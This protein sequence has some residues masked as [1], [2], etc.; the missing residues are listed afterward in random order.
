MAFVEEVEAVIAHYERATLCVGD[1]FMKI[2]T[3]QLR[4]DI[5]FEAMALAPISTSE[6]LWR[7][8][9]VLALT[10]LPG[11]AP[12]VNPRA[13]GSVRAGS[14]RLLPGPARRMMRAP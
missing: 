4:P 10:T 11:R 3:D 14:P 5:E 6:V 2:D 7:Q 1:V 12:I 13:L 8:P 9:P